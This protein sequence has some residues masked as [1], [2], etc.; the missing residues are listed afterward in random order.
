ML[1]FTEGI[2]FTLDRQGNYTWICETIKQ[3]SGYAAEEVIGT[4]ISKYVHPDDLSP[5]V[6]EINSAPIGLTLRSTFRVVDKNQDVLL[7]DCKRLV[8]PDAVLG[9]FYVITEKIIE[10]RRRKDDSI[11][12]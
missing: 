8:T 1:D 10:D 11:L 12:L 6:I 2:V 7:V 5:L 3:V 4:N 9:I